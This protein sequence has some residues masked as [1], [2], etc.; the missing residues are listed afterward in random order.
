LALLV[1]SAFPYRKNLGGRLILK[2]IFLIIT[3]LRGDKAN[4]IRAPHRS[5]HHSGIYA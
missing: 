5:E 2:I 3:I 1:L 4:D